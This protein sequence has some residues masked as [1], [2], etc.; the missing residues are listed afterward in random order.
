M[1]LSRIANQLRQFYCLSDLPP[2]DQFLIDRATARALLG[3][4]HRAQQV[5]DEL[6]LV[7]H[8]GDDL[9]VALYLAPTLMDALQRDDPFRQLHDNNLGSFCTAVE[10]ISHLSCVLWKFLQQMPVSQLELELQAEVDKFLCCA[11][12]QA[13]QHGERLA[14]HDRLFRR[15]RMADGCDALSIER[16]HTASTLAE[17]YCERIDRRYLRV[18]RLTALRGHLP[19]FYRLSHWEKLRLLQA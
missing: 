13:Q 6:L 7:S 19:R 5:P 8:R 1:I 15:Y 9:E 10:G 2:I 18:L 4:D 3:N 17:R 11:W 14:L 12:L 16:Y